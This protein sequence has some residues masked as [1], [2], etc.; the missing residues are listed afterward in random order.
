MTSDALSAVEP[1]PGMPVETPVEHTAAPAAVWSWPA[2]FAFRF[3]FAFFLLTTLPF[4][5]YYIPYV[6]MVAAPWQKFWRAVVPVV[7]EAVF[8]VSPEVLPNGSGDTTWNYV[9]IFTYGVLALLIAVVWSILDRRRLAYPRL[10]EGLRV[11]VRFALAAAMIGYGAAKVVQSQFPAPSLEKLV[12]PA[13]DMSPMGL[14]WFFMGYSKGYNFFT[15]MAELAGGLLLT[16]R[17]TTLLGA[18]VTIGVMANIVALNFFYDVPVKLY[19]SL[20]LLMAVFLAAPDFKRMLNFLVLNRTAP[21]DETAP[22]VRKPW[23]Q[24]AVIVVRTLI[25]VWF[26][27]YQISDTAAYMKEYQGQG[28]PLRGV[29]NVETLTVDGKDRPWILSDA[30]RLRRVVMDRPGYASLYGMDDARQ[31][32]TLKLDEKKKTLALK[33]RDDPKRVG[34]LTYDRK[35]ANTMTLAGKLDGK[36]IQAL[37]RKEPEKFFLTSRGFHWIQEYPLNR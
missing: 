34:L 27:W 2:R 19:S 11:F 29:W 4:P 36:D 3:A 14:L 13:G 23:A 1:M 35:D 31:R 10:L 22:L 18:L 17:R 26:V 24:A 12:Q 8:G 6:A 16:V 5:L 28:T 21:P 25:V 33:D 15:G 9:Q 30:K 7:G 20:L 32:F 37:L